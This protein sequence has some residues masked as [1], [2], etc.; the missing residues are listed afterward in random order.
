MG[1]GSAVGQG[2]RSPFEQ[3]E[4]LEQRRSRLPGLDR[5]RR[6]AAFL[7]SSRQRRV[8]PLGGPSRRADTWQT[9]HTSARQRGVVPTERNGSLRF[10]LA[11][12][13][14]SVSVRRTREL[15]PGDLLGG[16]LIPSTDCVHPGLLSGMLAESERSL[17]RGASGS[18]SRQLPPAKKNNS[19]YSAYN[20]EQFRK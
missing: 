1:S 18:S 4:V 8:V 13:G 11:G 15:L 19:S 12:T 16:R 9:G 14:L 5:D 10:C 2:S 20:P 6:I 17:A 3:N 7:S